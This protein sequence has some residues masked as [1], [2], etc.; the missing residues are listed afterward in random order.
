[1]E[2]LR[3]K[4]SERAFKESTASVEGENEMVG[5]PGGPTSRRKQPNAGASKAEQLLDSVFSAFHQNSD[6][7]A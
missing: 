1:M 2:F 6:V 5:G 3:K 4:E 7:S